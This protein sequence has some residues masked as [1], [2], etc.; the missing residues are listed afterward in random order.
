MSHPHSVPQT[1]EVFETVF[2]SN[3]KPD[4]VFRFRATRINGL[5]SPKVI[6]C[7]D[8][9][10]QVGRRCRVRVESVKKPTAKQ[11]GHIEVSFVGK[12]SLQLDTSFY[13][14]PLLLSKL[15]AMLERGMN[16]LLDG[17]H[18]SG[19]TVLSRLVAEALGMDYVFFN[20]AS[21]YEPTD[22]LASLQIGTSEAGHPETVWVTNDVYRA[23]IAANENPDMRTLVFLD[24]FNRCREMA[25]NGVMTGL[26]AT[27]RLHNPLT[28]G[29]L[30]IPDNVQWIAA[31]NNGP[32]YTGT[33]AVDPAQL[34]RFAP[35]KMGYPPP[36]AEKKLLAKL[37]PTVSPGDIDRIVNAADAIREE[38]DLGM[39]ATKEV[40]ELLEHPIFRDYSG[41]AVLELLK[42]SF[43]GRFHGQWDDA[44]T[45]AGTVWQV[46]VRRLKI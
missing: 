2:A 9:R 33:T 8:A 5:R 34:D 41:D 16:V 29:T 45:E 3:R 37:Y 31:I 43:C 25:R 28:N 26:D 4:S 13:A 23:L 21:L 44:S 6:L 46:I 12:S 22:I 11:R 40:C 17:P 32:Q 20:C 42:T 39:R 27:R 14:D 1:G 10:V 35:L 24:E 38:N 19:K 36:E 7:N 15:Q 30:K 18:G